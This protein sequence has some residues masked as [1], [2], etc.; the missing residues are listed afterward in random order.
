MG[1]GEGWTLLERDVVAQECA[2]FSGLMNQW[3]GFAD[4]QSSSS[5][6]LKSS[7][8]DQKLQLLSLPSLRGQ[9]CENL[10]QGGFS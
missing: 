3:P 10:R 7:I 1:T 5:P 9:L 6:K 2:S 4:S 8:N